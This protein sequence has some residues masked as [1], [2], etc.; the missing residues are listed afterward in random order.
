MRIRADRQ[1]NCTA[2][3]VEGLATI[4]RG[5]ARPL[6]YAQRLDRESKKV[7]HYLYFFRHCADPTKEPPKPLM[8]K[9]DLKRD[10][11]AGIA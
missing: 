11:R 1:P 8:T 5:V 6:R 10:R 7:P 4:L 3:S 9:E 2:S